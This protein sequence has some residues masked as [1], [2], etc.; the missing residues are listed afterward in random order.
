MIHTRN[1]KT[2]TKMKSIA[3]ATALLIPLGFVAP[4]AISAAPSTTKTISIKQVKTHNTA[5]DCWSIVNGKVYDLTDWV[6]KHP[7]GSKDIIRM[8][9]VNGSKGFNSEHGGDKSPAKDLAMYQ[10]GVVKK[11]I[12]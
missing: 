11:K 12:R 6:S 4:A 9:G 3:I 5:T 2:N 8:C 10:I 7:G 1:M